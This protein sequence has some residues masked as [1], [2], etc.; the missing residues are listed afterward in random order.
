MENCQDCKAKDKKIADLELSIKCGGTRELKL[1]GRVEEMQE[2]GILN[3]YLLD[4]SIEKIADLWSL[5]VGT[6]KEVLEK[7]LPG[8]VK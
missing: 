1:I 5:P 2:Q 8:K 3:C 4:P 6:V 7:R